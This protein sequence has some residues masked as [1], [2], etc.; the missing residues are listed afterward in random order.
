[1]SQVQIKL[2]SAGVREML[3]SPGVRADLD[4]RARR[5][6]AQAGPGMSAASSIGRRRALAMVWT[7]TPDAMAA[8]ATS[9]ALTRAIDAGR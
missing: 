8:E 1:V 4:S 3:R 6:A 7:D 9:R 2:N 5:I